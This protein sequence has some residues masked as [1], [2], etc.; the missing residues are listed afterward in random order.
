MLS[1]TDRLSP[2]PEVV[3]TRLDDAEVAL[4]DLA[5]KTYFSLNATGARAWSGIKAG[6]TLG[7]ICGALQEDYDVSQERAWES[8]CSLAGELLERGLVTRRAA[9]PPTG[10]AP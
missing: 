2:S 10:P 3:D 8:L 6:H 5:T 1:T 4:L 7:E 9:A